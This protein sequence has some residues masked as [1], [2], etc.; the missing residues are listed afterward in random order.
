MLVLQDSA[1]ATE[2]LHANPLGQN[3]AVD[4]QLP[5]WHV[6]TSC[7]PFV[8]VVAPHEVLSAATHVPDPLQLSAMQAPTL[9]KQTL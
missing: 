7:W 3:I 6:K 5:F 2:V 1:H 9:G 8:Q 4:A